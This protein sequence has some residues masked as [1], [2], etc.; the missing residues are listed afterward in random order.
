MSMCF[1]ILPH[2][3]VIRTIYEREF[4]IR[5]ER[6]AWCLK[7]LKF[8]RSE[9][10]SAETSRFEKYSLVKREY[11]KSDFV[12]GKVVCISNLDF[13]TNRTARTVINHSTIE[14]LKQKTGRTYFQTLLQNFIWNITGI[15][16]ILISYQIKSILHIAT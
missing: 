1:Y 13:C 6:T 14:F 3:N 5:F 2:N 7:S 11:M 9:Y 12:R 8:A 15:S 10:A 4:G 16:L